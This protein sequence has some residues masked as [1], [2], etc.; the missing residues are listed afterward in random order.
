MNTIFQL[1]TIALL[2]LNLNRNLLLAKNRTILV[3]ILLPEEI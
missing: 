2:V 3:K 1:R